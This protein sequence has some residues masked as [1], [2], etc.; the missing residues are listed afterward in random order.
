MACVGMGTSGSFDN[1]EELHVMKYNKAMAT[2]D[3]KEWEGSNNE[4]HGLRV[5]RQVWEAI[6]PEDVPKGA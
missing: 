4:E 6:P 5:K 3:K 1:T 2:E